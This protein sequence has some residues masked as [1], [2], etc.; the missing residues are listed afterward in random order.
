[1]KELELKFLEIDK[2]VL[3]QKLE[4][5][6]ARLTVDDV[7]K[8]IYFDYPDHRIRDSREVFRIRTFGDKVE[9]GRKINPRFEDEC[10][11]FD[12]IEVYVSDFDEAVELVESLGFIRGLHFEKHRTEYVLPD[13]SKF[14]IDTFPGVPTFLEVEAIDWNRIQELIEEFGLE[15]YEQT[16]L[17][18]QE[19]LKQKYN[20]EVNGLT[21]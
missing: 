19:L 1:M 14:E 12:E 15:D 3:I 4:S 8:T 2:D 17:I 13:G 18:G 6:G 16:N 20:V 11:V 5:V 21:F 7:L 9:L 10:K